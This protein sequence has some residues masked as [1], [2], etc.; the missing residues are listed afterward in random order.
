MSD[1]GNTTSLGGDA[2][3]QVNMPVSKKPGNSPWDEELD[4]DLDVKKAPIIGSLDQSHPAPAAAPATTP[5]AV[6]NNVEEKV[7]QKVPASNFIQPTQ[8]PPPPETEPTGPVATPAAPSVPPISNPSPVA[9]P[10]PNVET[11][12][13]PPSNMPKPVVNTIDNITASPNP[14][15]VVED[16]A[17]MVPAEQKDSSEEVPTTGA[18]SPEKQSIFAKLLPSKQKNVDPVLNPEVSPEM[19]A[20]PQSLSDATGQ[21]PQIESPNRGGA[22]KKIFLFGAIIVVIFVFLSVLTELGFISLGLEKA[23]GAVGIEGLWGGLSKSPE[24]AIALSFSKMKTNTSYKAEGTIKITVDGQGQSTIISPLIS[25]VGGLMLARDTSIGQAIKAIQAA[26]EDY[27]YNLYNIDETATGTGSTTTT[28]TT[29]TGSSLTTT[30]SGT[31]AAST[32]DTSATATTTTSP[33]EDALQVIEAGVS[34]KAGTDGAE[35]TINVKDSVNSIIEIVSQHNNLYVKTNG[36][37]KYNAAATGED[38]TGYQI[39]TLKEKDIQTEIFNLK[40]NSGLSVT[41]SRSGN[42]KIGGVRC[43]RY[44]IDNVELG[45]SLSDLG[46]KSDMTQTVSGDVWIGIKDKLVRK[47]T[48]NITTPVSATARIINVDLTF[49]DFGVANA[50]TAVSDAITASSDQANATAPTTD[51]SQTSAATTDETSSTALTGDAK[52]KSDIGKIAAALAEYYEAHSSYPLAASSVKLNTANNILATALV[53]TYISSLPLD[54][55][56]NWYYGYISDGTT[57]TLSAR[58]E[59]I[60][61]P[62]GTKSGSISLYLKHP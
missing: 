20:A 5:F 24:K 46:I 52:R 17:D 29:A 42:E 22:G 50:I 18:M 62:A 26:A 8:T 61:D 4:P 40:Q 59:N 33:T 55:T 27:E 41:G 35:S 11:I 58:L 57:Y 32:T 39:G 44:R 51:S 25:S 2:S 9:P 15:A 6:P 19:I 3:P 53:P 60:N 1:Q 31:A 23:Y 56:A 37:I 54:A 13:A 14:D 36:A 48:L 21:A 43:Y 7:G 12:T 10:V 30:G 47:I 38:W 16:F 28:G 49:S 34:L 45:N